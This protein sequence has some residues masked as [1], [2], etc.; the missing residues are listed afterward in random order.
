MR[1]KLTIG[2]AI[3]CLLL[4]ISSPAYAGYDWSLHWTRIGAIGS[5]VGSLFSFIALVIA[6]VALVMPYR[7]RLYMDFYPSFNLKDREELYEIHIGNTGDR[8]VTISNVYLLVGKEE[9]PL[10]W[11]GKMLMI[12][13]KE[14]IPP[15]PRRLE[16]GQEMVVYG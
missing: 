5:W 12:Y 8:P 7:V 16:Q 4:L 9:V 14:S 15:V 3:V 2:I 1:T 6:I 10:Q 11:M 13:F